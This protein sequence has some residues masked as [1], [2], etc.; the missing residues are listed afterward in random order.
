ML[1]SVVVPVFNDERYLEKCLLSIARQTYKDIEVIIVNDG[2]TDNSIKICDFFCQT[3]ARF[4]VIHKKNSGVSDSRNRGLELASGDYICFVDSDDWIEEDYFESVEPLLSSNKY[5]II[6]N[7]LIT[8]KLNGTKF[9]ETSTNNSHELSQDDAIGILFYENLF[10]WGVYST[11]YKKDFIKEI[12]FNPES[13]FGED[14]EFKYKAIRSSKSPLY[15]SCL[16]KYHYIVRKDSSIVSYSILKKS[17][18]LKIIKNV[19]SQEKTALR[20]ILFYKQYIPRLLAYAIEGTI[21]Y[22]LQEKNRG[23]EFR[24]E[25]KSY[26]WKI[27]FSSKDSLISKV[28]MLILMAPSFLRKK[29]YL[30]FISDN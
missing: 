20:D 14:F 7:P 17:D 10:S 1:I 16:T 6:F 11:F 30:Y 5:S 25:A 4:K 22:N 23:V 24:T 29:N 27:M 13:R 2:S 28:K 21:S 15:Y 3:D 18:N 8:E 9:S 26:K 12:R 19:M